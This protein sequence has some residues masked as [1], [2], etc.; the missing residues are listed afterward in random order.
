MEDPEPGMDVGELADA[1]TA[2]GLAFGAMELAAERRRARAQRTF[3]DSARAS[4]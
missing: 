2:L 1:A 3:R 4:S